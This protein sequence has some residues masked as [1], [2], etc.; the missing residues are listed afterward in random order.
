MSL[1][2]SR[3]RFLDV[4]R[5][6]ALVSPLAAAC[7]GAPVPLANSGGGTAASASASASTTVPEGSDPSTGSGPCRCSW[8]TKQAA[9]PRVC[10]KGEPSYEGVPCV[11]GQHYPSGE[12]E[13][14]PPTL[15]PLEPP[16]LL[17]ECS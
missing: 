10:K 8:D 3:Q 11:P 5:A 6:L 16:D 4:A 15:G 14:D 2:V 17:A 7:G 12:G 9:A 13:M 1:T